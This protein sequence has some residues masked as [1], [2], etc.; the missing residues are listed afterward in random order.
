MKSSFV[1]SVSHDSE[2]NELIFWLN[3]KE[4]RYP[5]VSEGAYAT[6]LVL[7]LDKGSLGKAYNIFIKAH[8]QIMKNM[9]E[10]PN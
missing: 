6:F 2:K 8:K 1:D 5:H 10:S 3:G 7:A 9:A 4:Y